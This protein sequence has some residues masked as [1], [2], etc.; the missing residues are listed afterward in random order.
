MCT[1]FFWIAMI[2]YTHPDNFYLKTDTCLDVNDPLIN[3]YRWRVVRPEDHTNKTAFLVYFS[4]DGER[5]VQMFTYFDA[6][7]S[8]QEV[9]NFAFEHWKQSHC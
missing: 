6:N 2:A 5:Q 1:L 8:D 9:V 3:G 7:D 4:L